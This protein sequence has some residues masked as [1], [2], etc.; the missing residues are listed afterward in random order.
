M[1]SSDIHS[2]LISQE[3]PQPS[4]TKICLKIT[5]LKFHSNLPGVNELACNIP[6]P[7]EAMNNNQ[8]RPAWVK[9]SHKLSVSILLLILPQTGRAMS[10]ELYKKWAMQ[11]PPESFVH[12]RVVKTA[13]CQTDDHCIGVILTQTWAQ[14]I[15]TCTLC[16][17]IS[18][19][20]L[21]IHT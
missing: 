4:I 18:E 3:M 5:C 21:L 20:N 1:K 7:P 9:L 17:H 13:R 16:I 11:Y 15:T 14:E 8:D 12:G 6:L 2:R 10:Y 19:W